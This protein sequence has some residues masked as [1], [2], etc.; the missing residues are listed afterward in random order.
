MADALSTNS[1]PLP[2]DESALKSHYDV[3]QS[4][5][6]Y[7][8]VCDLLEWTLKNRPRDYPFSDGYTPRFNLVKFVVLA[9]LKFLN[10]ICINPHWFDWLLGKKIT[11]QTERL[12]G[13]Y[14]KARVGR[15]QTRAKINELRGYIDDA[16]WNR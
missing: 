5:P 8:R 6:A 15:A 13:Y 12:M 10:T 16:W 3:D 14:K 7:M 1:P 4:Y 9:G 2:V 11:D